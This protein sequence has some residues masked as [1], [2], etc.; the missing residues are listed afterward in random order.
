MSASASNKNT[1]NVVGFRVHITEVPVIPILHPTAI[2]GWF[3]G[4]QPEL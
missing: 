4:C 1:L 3:A 2:T